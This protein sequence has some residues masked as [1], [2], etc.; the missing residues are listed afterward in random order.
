MIWE[1][2]CDCESTLFL[3]EAA[4]ACD[5]F[6][7][8]C[9]AN[10]CINITELFQF[11]YEGQLAFKWTY[12]PD[13]DLFTE[14]RFDTEKGVPTEC[15]LIGRHSPEESLFT[16][17]NCE[18]CLTDGTDGPQEM[19]IRFNCFNMSTNGECVAMD[20]HGQ[21]NFAQDGGASNFV[22]ASTPIPTPGPEGESSLT[23]EFYHTKCDDECYYILLTV[24]I[25]LGCFVLL[26]LVLTF[27]YILKSLVT[28]KTDD[29]RKSN[30][31]TDKETDASSASD[32]GVMTSPNDN[33]K[34]GDDDC[35]TFYL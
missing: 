7:P 2:F 28:S 32:I 3:Y 8:K 27:R 5:L 31:L 14:V 12:S 17:S 19:G 18:P 20:G 1:R 9:F 16:C 24:V 11:N 22:K 25:V 30:T 13:D 33:Q 4:I 34:H 23:T 29:F 21:Y 15:G 6:D 26:G 10:E 35:D